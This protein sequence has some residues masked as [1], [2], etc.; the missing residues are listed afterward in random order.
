M[1][2]NASVKPPTTEEAVREP[3]ATGT[4]QGPRPLFPLG[5]GP[6]IRHRHIAGHFKGSSGLLAT[7]SRNTEIP[8]AQPRCA[9]GP[10]PRVCVQ[11]PPTALVATGRLTSSAT[12]PPPWPDPSAPAS[13]SPPAAPSPGSLGLGTSTGV[14]VR[15]WGDRQPVHVQQR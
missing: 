10:H 15:D 11:P 12:R 13:A 1:G 5:R 2:V 6:L 4:R 3:V 14:R 7:T 9:L 8:S